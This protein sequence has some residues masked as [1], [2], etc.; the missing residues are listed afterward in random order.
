MNMK[1]LLS[2]IILFPSFSIAQSTES[3]PYIGLQGGG[4]WVSSQYLKQQNI[5]FVRMNFKEPTKSGYTLGIVSGWNLASGFRPEIELS[6]RKNSLS[7]FDERHYEGNTAIEGLG[8]E[9]FSGFF[10]NLWYDIPINLQVSEKVNIKPYIGA[11]VGHGRLTIENLKAGG[12][13]FG[14]TF[15]DNV[16][17]WQLGTGI[18]MNYKRKYSASLN[19]RYVKTSSAEYKNNGLPLL[20]PDNIRTRYKAYTTALEMR[21]NF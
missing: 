9:S 19:Y 4:N 5:N 6:H 21:Y 15:K 11:G 10:A 8:S 17:A 13:P 7:S 1:L 16:N 14:E 2:P 12:V 3:G 18:T 20:P